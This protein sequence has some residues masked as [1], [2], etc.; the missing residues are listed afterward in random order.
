MEQ[1]ERIKMGELAR[2]SGVPR[3]RI[4]YYLREGLLHPPSKTGRTTGYYNRSHLERLRMIEKTRAEYLEVRKLY[5]MPVS[6]LR[7]EIER[8]ESRDGKKTRTWST[9]EFEEHAMN[10][11]ER[12]LGAALDLYMERGYYHTSLKDIAGKIGISPS[13]IYLHFPD[14]KE[15]FIEVV[16]NVITGLNLKVEEVMLEVSDPARLTTSLFKVYYDNY[17]KLGEIIGQLRAGV[18]TGDEWARERLSE[19]YRD[20]TAVTRK[21]VSLGI[22]NGHIRDMDLDILTGFV[23]AVFEGAIQLSYV[24]A[25]LGLKEVIQGFINMAYYGLAPANVPRPS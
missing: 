13:S 5:R 8:V 18:S 11:R 20:L 2:R 9:G 19:L 15:L 22:A 14:K 4:H 7:M 24:N 16:R 25:R 21:I 17:P 10:I 23:S 6:L 3:S 12:I 1:P